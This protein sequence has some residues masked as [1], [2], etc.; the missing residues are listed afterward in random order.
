MCFI[1]TSLEFRTFGHTSKLIVS[2]PIAMYNMNSKSANYSLHF[3]IAV[4]AF[5]SKCTCNKLYCH[6]S[7]MMNS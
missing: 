6:V 2:V 7:F 3:L 5:A 4:M 1:N